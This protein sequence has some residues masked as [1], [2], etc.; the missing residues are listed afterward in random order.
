MQQLMSSMVRLTNMVVFLPT[1][2]YCETRRNAI[3]F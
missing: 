2:L 1:A 3:Q